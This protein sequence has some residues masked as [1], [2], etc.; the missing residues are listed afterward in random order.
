M[1]YRHRTRRALRGGRLQSSNRCRQGVAD[2]CATCCAARS[3]TSQAPS[4]IL[5][6]L[7]KNVKGL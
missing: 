1:P 7:T 2:R 4:P 6:P 5:T 3:C